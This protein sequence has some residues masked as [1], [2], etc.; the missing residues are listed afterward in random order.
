MVCKIG[1]GKV[2][3]L[4]SQRVLFHGLSLLYYEALGMVLLQLMYL[5]LIWLWG[6]PWSCGF[7]V[8]SAIYEEQYSNEAYIGCTL[9]AWSSFQLRGFKLTQHQLSYM[10]T[11][12]TK[13]FYSGHLPLLVYLQW[14]WYCMLS[15]TIVFLFKLTEAGRQR[16]LHGWPNSQ[17]CKKSNNICLP[18]KRKK[19]NN[20]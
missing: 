19:C 13:H 9:C 4:N 16:M 20:M 5:I 14:G 7:F 15:I 8:Q 1:G 3:S 10:V 18:M 12:N 6:N 11:K 2:N 17:Y